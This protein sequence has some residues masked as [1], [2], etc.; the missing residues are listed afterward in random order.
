MIISPCYF[1]HLQ[2]NIF[3]HKKDSSLGA[4][5]ARKTLFAAGQSRL[6]AR[7]VQA[8]AGDEAGAGREDQR[9]WTGIRLLTAILCA[10]ERALHT[11]TV[12]GSGFTLD[13][14]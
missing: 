13:N 9:A 3:T 1:L 14:H 6:L 4:H 10:V 8:G 11:Q 2:F 12:D 7:K 5:T